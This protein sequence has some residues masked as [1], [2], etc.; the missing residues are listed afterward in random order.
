[1]QR[2]NEAKRDSNVMHYLATLKTIDKQNSTLK[3]MKFCTIKTLSI[4]PIK[5]LS[6]ISEASQLNSGI[7][8][9]S[10][11]FPKE[12]HFFLS[13]KPGQTCSEEKGNRSSDGSCLNI[14]NRTRLLP[15]HILFL[16]TYYT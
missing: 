8:S 13:N 1:M 4:S 11:A 15:H 6:F 7:Q 3:E 5:L 14:Y 10:A 2:Y 16:C 12:L 9:I